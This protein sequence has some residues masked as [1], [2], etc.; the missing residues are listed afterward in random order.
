M[1]TN[2]Y[3]CAITYLQHTHPDVPHFDDEHWTWLRGAL[4]T[5]DRTMCACAPNDCKTSS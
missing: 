1:I 2:F 4:S 3:L 5:I